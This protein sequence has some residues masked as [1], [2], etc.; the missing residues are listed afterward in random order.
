MKMQSYIRK[1][2]AFPIT[3]GGN[4]RNTIYISAQNGG[5][6]WFMA[7][8]YDG[9]P[10]IMSEF[11][12]CRVAAQKIDPSE[13][14]RQLTESVFKAYLLSTGSSIS[15]STPTKV[16]ATSAMKSFIRKDRWR[17]AALLQPITQKA[18]NSK[19]MPLQSSA[20]TL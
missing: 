11:M 3:C 4:W 7:V 15:T 10:V 6:G 12:L 13:R 2:Y 5:P 8:G 18:P 1:L 16:F 19:P 9:C 20:I 14:K 17:C